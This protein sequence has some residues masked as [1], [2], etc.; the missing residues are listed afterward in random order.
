MDKLLVVAFG[1]NAL[2]S[3][4]H[5]TDFN[6]QYECL[7]QSVDNILSLQELGW[8]ILIVHGNGPQVGFSLQR[9]EIAKKEVSPISIDY[10]VAE[11]QGSIGFMFQRAI[12]N[13][14]KKRNLDFQVATLIT[15]TLVDRNDPAFLVPSKPVGCFMTEKQA[16]E[17]ELALG[18]S[19]MEDSGRGFRRTVASPEPKKV[20]ETSIIKSLLERHSIVIAGGGGGIAVCEDSQ[21]YLSG[22]EAVIDKDLTAALLAIELNARYL[23]ISTGVPKV[24]I[25]FG[26]PNQQWLDKLSKSDAQDLIDK[27]EF[28][29]GSMLPKIEALLKYISVCPKGC[30]II[31]TPALMMDAL[32][33]KNGTRIEGTKYAPDF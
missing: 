27:G 19:V 9:S 1:G 2:I 4:P 6:H 26:K 17:K 18:W 20:L 23:L 14:L 24:A 32:L 33:S 22:V 21:G 12:Y 15:Q 29:E 7:S 25:N 28:G 10:A 8:K 16:K 30:G 3:D 5:R 13:E 31:T 11:S